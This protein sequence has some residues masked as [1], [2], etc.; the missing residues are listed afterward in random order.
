[1]INQSI[2]TLDLMVLVLGKPVQVEATFSNHRLK[3]RIEV[4]DT[5]EAFIRFERADALFYASNAYV[6][7]SPILLEIVCEKGKFRID[8]NMLT[9]WDEAG[10][11]SKYEF[12]TASLNGKAYWGDSHPACIS[13]FYDSLR[14]NRSTKVGL[15][16]VKDT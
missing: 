5:L 11:R 10:N 9:V 13:D 6:D 4:E 7:D 8:G 1:M 14:E 12:Q 16:S 3:G 2:H 15:E